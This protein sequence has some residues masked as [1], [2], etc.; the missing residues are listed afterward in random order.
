MFEGLSPRTKVGNNGQ[1]ELDYSPNGTLTRGFPAYVDNI[2]D[3][4]W[5]QPQMLSSNKETNIFLWSSDISE[6]KSGRTAP[7]HCTEDGKEEFLW[8]ILTRYLGHLL[9]LVKEEGSF[10][11]LNVSVLKQFVIALLGSVPDP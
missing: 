4:N 8:E 5:L 1:S 2:Q 10:W 6:Q 3:V 9:T 7:L 11:E